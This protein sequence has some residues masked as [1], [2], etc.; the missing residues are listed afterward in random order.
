MLAR[1]EVGT[2]K[3]MVL[4][5]AK[6]WIFSLIFFSYLDGSFINASLDSGPL[7]GYQQVEQ[8]LLGALLLC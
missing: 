2:Y 7:F 6:S 3:A 4:H 1:M 8:G 5:Y